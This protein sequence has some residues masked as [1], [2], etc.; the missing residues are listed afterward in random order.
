MTGLSV[1]MWSLG[2]LMFELLSG[3]PA[4]RGAATAEVYKKVLEAP[5]RLCNAAGPPTTALL[6]GLLAKHAAAR[7]GCGDGGAAALRQA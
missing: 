3:F 7:L 2:M 1:D 5:H 4:F 6:D